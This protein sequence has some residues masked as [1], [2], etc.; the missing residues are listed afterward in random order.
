M[1]LLQELSLR[2]E[3][4]TIP[5]TL[6]VRRYNDQRTTLPRLLPWLG[7]EGARIRFPHLRHARDYFCLVRGTD[8]LSPG[9][10][11]RLEVA[12]AAYFLGPWQWRGYAWDVLRGSRILGTER[13][14]DRPGEPLPTRTASPWR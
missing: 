4:H 8:L 9:Q 2:G 11:L 7:G 5:E 6:A 3:F 12:L 10:R 14:A 1:L 13:P